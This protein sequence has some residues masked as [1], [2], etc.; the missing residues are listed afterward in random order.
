MDKEKTGSQ[1]V[2]GSNCSYAFPHKPGGR[3]ALSFKGSPDRAV[4][5]LQRPIMWH[6]MQ[7]QRI[8]VSITKT[9]GKTLSATAKGVDVVG[10]DAQV[11]V[12]G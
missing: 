11:G 4:A 5:T 10:A 6:S 2:K 7:P 12:G 1:A 8:Q 9:V 3:R